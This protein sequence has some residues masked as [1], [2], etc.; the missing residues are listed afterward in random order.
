MANEESILGLLLRA[1]GQCSEQ[2]HGEEYLH[3][4]D[5]AVENYRHAVRSIG[6]AIN[7]VVIAEMYVRIQETRKSM[8]KDFAKKIEVKDGLL[9]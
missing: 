2:K 4:N 7:S 5:N 8:E 1:Y 9:P 3:H 6:D